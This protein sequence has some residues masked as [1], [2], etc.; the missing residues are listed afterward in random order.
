VQVADES[1][2]VPVAEPEPGLEIEDDAETEPLGEQ[3][4]VSRKIVA[5]KLLVIEKLAVTADAALL[6]P[7]ASR[8]ATIIPPQTFETDLSVFLIVASFSL[9]MPP[10]AACFVSPTVEL[11]LIAW[12]IA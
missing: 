4:A 10:C 3:L 5:P 9:Q 2:D 6:P 1:V 12:R 7:I 11:G 8:P